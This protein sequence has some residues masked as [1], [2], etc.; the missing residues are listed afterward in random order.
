LRAV[1][2]F[3]AAAKNSAVLADFARALAE[4][5]TSQ[6]VDE[7]GSREAHGVNGA[8]S[9]RLSDASTRSVN[10]FLCS[11]PLLDSPPHTRPAAQEDSDDTG[12]SVV[13]DTFLESTIEISSP[14]SGDIGG[15]T[16]P[17]TS[18]GLLETPLEIALP[19]SHGTDEE[20]VHAAL[21]NA[22]ATT[23]RILPPTTTVA[24]G[25]AP[26]REKQMLFYCD[27]IK[28][29]ANARRLP[30]TGLDRQLRF[31][32]E[33]VALQRAQVRL[34]ER[35]LEMIRDS[36]KMYRSKS[37]STSYSFSGSSLR[38]DVSHFRL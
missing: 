16:P 1:G 38:I 28:T 29:K 21:P 34:H 4:L 2:A 36:K 26:G 3:R 7:S 25:A 12:P 22:E 11:Q 18:D 13:P 27:L 23:R 5:E 20:D 35:Q 24:A 9:D 31:L 8:H 6:V 15:V 33:Q 10:E 30:T 17:L 37:K 19:E 32:E 14:E